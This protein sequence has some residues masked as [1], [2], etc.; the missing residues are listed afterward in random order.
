MPMVPAK[1]ALRAPATR[2][3]DCTAPAIPQRGLWKSPDAAES[4]SWNG[5]ESTAL[6]V[7][8]GLLTSFS[9][10][11]PDKVYKSRSEAKVLEFEAQLE[12]N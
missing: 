12:K 8:R 10:Q 1:M 3:S 6:K 5:A 11:R 7:S 9:Y 2:R 4:P